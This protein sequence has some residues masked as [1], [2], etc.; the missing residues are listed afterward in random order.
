MVKLLW[1]EINLGN[2]NRWYMRDTHQTDAEPLR[3]RQTDSR[4]ERHQSFCPLIDL[5]NNRLE[6]AEHT[7]QLNAVL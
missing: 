4:T 7:A 5:A 3:L 1:D 6:H 2:P